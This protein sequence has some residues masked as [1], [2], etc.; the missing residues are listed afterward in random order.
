[1]PLHLLLV[2][3]SPF[4]Y[5]ISDNLSDIFAGNFHTNCL[6]E[7]QEFADRPEDHGRPLAESVILVLQAVPGHVRL[8]HLMQECVY[9]V[10]FKRAFLNLLLLF[11]K[12]NVLI[13]T[14]VPH[15]KLIDQIFS[16]LRFLFLHPLGDQVADI[17]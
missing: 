5:P 13:P 7:S 1:M 10:E 16:F 15:E 9:D 12:A 2:L 17:R 11:A 3:G 8:G 14:G 4:F 6:Q